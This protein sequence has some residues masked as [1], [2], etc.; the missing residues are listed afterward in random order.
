[1]GMIRSLVYLAGTLALSGIQILGQES[2][3][4]SKPKSVNQASQ[5]HLRGII[6]RNELI[7]S[8][9][10]G[11]QFSGTIKVTGQTTDCHAVDFVMQD[12][13]IKSDSE[14]GSTKSPA[15]F[16]IF[17][18]GIT[19]QFADHVCIPA[20]GATVRYRS[21]VSITPEPGGGMGLSGGALV[22]RGGFIVTGR[23]TV[24]PPHASSAVEFDPSPQAPLV[25][26]LTDK[27]FRYISGMGIVK[28]PSGKVY[29]FPV[30]DHPT[31]ASVAH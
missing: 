4:T 12:V 1:M 8:D 21:N 10:D 24:I 7:I 11:Q 17:Y 20:K 22:T 16:S 14:G 15:N 31:P 27:G 5:P 18:P 19:F 3:T 13:H 28:L 2:A 26:E 9:V 30:A 6:P 23:E 29:K 25:F